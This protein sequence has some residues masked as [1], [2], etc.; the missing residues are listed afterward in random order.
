MLDYDIVDIIRP[1][2]ISFMQSRFNT[3]IE[4]KA[5]NQPLK[6]GTNSAP[7]VYWY[8][9]PTKRYGSP[10]RRS[11]W[12]E[13]NTQMRY[14]ETQI[15]ETTFQLNALVKQDVNNLTITANDLLTQ[16]SFIMQSQEFLDRL[17]TNNLSI[18]RITEIRNTYFE[19]DNG[20][21]EDNPS[22]DVVIQHNQTITS[23]IN[24]INRF[25]DNTRRV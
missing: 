3:T 11:F 5:G 20:G 18:Y 7:T 21:Y 17:N 24:H 25:E 16:V 12:D 4:F 19:S 8:S 13:A 1:A 10:R 6:V 2:I 23:D 22:F 15:L 14:E 9:L